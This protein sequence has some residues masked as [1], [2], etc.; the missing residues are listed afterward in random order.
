[1]NQQLSDDLAEA[2]LF[3]SLF[4]VTLDINSGVYQACCA[5]HPP[6]LLRDVNGAVHDID[7]DGMI[8]GFSTD[9]DYEIRQGQLEA[10]SCLLLYTDGITENLNPQREMFG[11]E[12]L[13]QCFA[14]AEAD[15]EQ[16]LNAVDHAMFQW[17]QGHRQDDC[18]M[19]CISRDR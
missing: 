16:V 6:M 14:E 19:L 2:G 8:L 5:G 9:A 15:A 7:T 3:V 1:M 18:T 13:K 10:G 17:S 4:I 11:D 12:R